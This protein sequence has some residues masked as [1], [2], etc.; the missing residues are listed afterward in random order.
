MTPWAPLI[1]FAVGVAYLALLIIL[2]LGG[3]V[4]AVSGGGL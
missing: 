1:L 2:C 3:M 4:W